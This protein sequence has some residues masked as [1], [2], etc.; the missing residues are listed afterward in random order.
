M[1]SLDLAGKINCGNCKFAIDKKC[2]LG[3]NNDLCFP[4]FITSLYNDSFSNSELEDI[5]SI[6]KWREIYK[7]NQSDI[8]ILFDS[9]N[10]LVGITNNNKKMN[11]NNQ[12]I[13]YAL[14]ETFLGELFL[15][16]GNYIAPNSEKISRIVPWFNSKNKKGLN[17]NF[18]SLENKN[19]IFEKT[20]AER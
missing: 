14:A 13:L 5:K 16:T 2:P 8:N 10:K 4:Y 17:L 3:T 7:T 18:L 20:G 12:I 1:I 15:Q 6:S 19:M 9:Y 11:T